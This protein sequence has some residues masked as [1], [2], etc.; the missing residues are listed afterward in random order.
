METNQTKPESA[1]RKYTGGCHCGAVSFEALLDP[2]RGAGRCNCSICTKTGV[3]GMIIKPDAFRVLEGADQTGTYQW[4]GKIS[5]RHFCKHCGVQVFGQGHLAEIGGDFVSVNILCLDDL[6]FTP[7]SINYWD[8]R[9]NNWAAG[10]R[11]TPWPA[12]GPSPAE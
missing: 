10:P 5:T 3:T 4:G 2:S 6:E 12:A 11:P 1:A 9:H 7:S 8:G